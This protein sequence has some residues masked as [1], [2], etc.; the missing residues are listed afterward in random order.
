MAGLF[1]AADGGVFSDVVTVA[2]HLLYSTGIINGRLCTTL[3]YNYR[4][5]YIW[6]GEE[7]R[8]S[9]NVMIV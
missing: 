8:D 5:V 3:H 9:Y 2:H 1:T 6:G 4:A 7:T